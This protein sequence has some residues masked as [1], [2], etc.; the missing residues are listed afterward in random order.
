MATKLNT[1]VTF[2]FSVCIVTQ[3]S[4]TDEIHAYFSNDSLNGLKVSDAYETHN[5][6]VIYSNEEYYIKLDLGLVSPDMHIYRNEYRSANRSFGEL[7]S[8]EIGEPNKTSSDTR[9]YARIRATGKFGI[10]RLQDF[11]H[12]LLSL[13]SVDKVNDL[14]R[15]P[16][17]TWFGVGLRSDFQ[18]SPLALQD[19]KI[20]LDG[21][22]GSDTARLNV[23][24]TKEFHYSVFKYDFSLGGRVIGYD[25]LVS[26][27]PINAQERSIIPEVSFGVSYAKGPYSIFVRD[28][29]SLPSIK[30]D[31]DL[32]GVLSMGV[33]YGF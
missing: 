17:E 14:I 19:M 30:T 11:A 16:T 10:D 13:Q 2:I 3:V 23:K 33:S 24:V 18:I 7:I 26:A 5:M 29:F 25:K 8:L 9:L 31:N 27:P 22:V 28:S 4:A 1:F 12:R 32:Y 21:F 20:N 6:G 15:M